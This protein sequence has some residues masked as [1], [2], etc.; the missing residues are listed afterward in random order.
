MLEPRQPAEVVIPVENRSLV[1]L[2]LDAE[3]EFVPR[4]LDPTSSDPR[5]LGVWV[6]LVTP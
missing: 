3:F 2:E 6:E 4:E 1:T 5:S